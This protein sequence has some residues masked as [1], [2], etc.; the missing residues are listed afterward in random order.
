VDSQTS[1]SFG[2]D[3]FVILQSQALRLRLINDRGQLFLDFQ[4]VERGGERDWFSIDVVL[5]L[6]TNERPDSAELDE[7]YAVFLR[8]HLDE[9]EHRFRAA[10][11]KD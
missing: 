4:S 10:D 2:G 3:A 5:T 7:K 11:R 8:K 6:L 1:S 9:I